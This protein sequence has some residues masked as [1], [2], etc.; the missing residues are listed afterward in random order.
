MYSQ[1]SLKRLSDYMA[2]LDVHGYSCSDE[3]V[4][5]FNKIILETAKETVTFK[6]GNK[7]HHKCKYK[8]LGWIKT[9]LA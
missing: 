2:S 1:I 4:Q 5:N 7:H 3:A 6:L 8:N 9:A